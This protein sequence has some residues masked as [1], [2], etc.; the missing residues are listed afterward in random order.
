M[1][2]TYRQSSKVDPGLL[3]LDPENKLYA[4]GPRFR[5]SAHELRDQAL[6]LS[7]MLSDKIGGPSVR[8]YQPPGLWS[9]VSF[10]SKSRSTDFYVPD[11]GDNLYRRS[12]YT[13]WKRSVA[14][15]Q[16]MTFDAAGRE[17]CVVRMTRTSTP[18]QALTLLNDTTF[19]EAARGLAQRMMLDGG[20]TPEKRIVFGL[21]LAAAEP[22]PK[23][24]AI[25]SRGFDD[26][27][28]HFLAQPEAAKELLATGESR[29]DASLPPVE[30][31]AYTLVASTILNL[32]QTITKE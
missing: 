26:Y 9:D 10:Q 7:G 6:A 21:K 16:M 32:D 18:L 3:E 30:L 27:R 15:P 4:R 11:T 1:S 19:V 17:A 25:L 29:S 23:T 13:F 22:T 2:A 5:L 20:A 28:A 31:A 8:P 24:V 12:L 14:P